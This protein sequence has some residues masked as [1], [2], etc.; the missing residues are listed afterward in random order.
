[1]NKGLSLYPNTKL[2]TS[3]SGEYSGGTQKLLRDAL[4]YI[5]PQ[6]KNLM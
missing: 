3:S 6:L 1:M 5:S 2:P 4:L